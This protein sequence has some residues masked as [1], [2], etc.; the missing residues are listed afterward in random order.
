MPS[1]YTVNLGIEKPA[2]GEQSGTWGDTTNLNFDI[3]DQAI[4]GAVSITLASAGT[5]GSPNTL[6]ISDGAVSDG[7]NKW[8]EFVDGGDLGATAYVQLT[9]N[10]AEKIV[11]VRNSLSGSRS[12]ILFQGTYDAGRDLEVPAGVDMLVKFDGGGATATTTNVFQRL[13]VENLNIAGTTTVNGVID[14]DTM[15]TASA[16]TLATSESIKAYVDT[17]AA[18]Q[19][20]LSEV[21]ANGN[22]TGGTDIAVSS[23]DDITFA[24]NSKAIFGASSDL[25]IYHSGSDSW[26]EDNGA[27]NLYIDT[28][29]AGI[30]LSYN[31]SAENMATFTANGAVTLYYDNAAKFATTST[32]VDITGAF[33]ATTTGTVPTIYGGSGASQTF[34][35]QSTSGNSNHSKVLIGNTVGADNGG[36]SFY[37][38]GT[39]VATERMR[40]SGT[41]GDITFYDTSGN[42]SF[43]YDE[44][45]GSTFNEQ[46]ENKDFRVES[47]SN[48]NMLFVDA[49]VDRVYVGTA[50]GTSGNLVVASN[51]GA[52][53][54]QIN[55]RVGD[56]YG[57]LNFYNNA[58]DTAWGA[59]AGYSGTGL[60]FYQGT[61]EIFRINNS[62]AIF[63][64]AGNNRDF[65]VESDGNAYAFFVDADQD[66]VHIGGSGGNY[67]A[68]I[69]GNTVNSP[70]G[71]LYVNAALNNS[72]RGVFIDA[73][74]RTE[75]DNSTRLLQVRDRYAYNALT[76]NVGGTVEINDDGG[77]WGDFRVESDA[78]ANM[79]WVDAGQNRVKIATASD[80]GAGVLNID[81]AVYFANSSNK[82][83]QGLT[84]TGWGYSPGTYG[85]IQ[86]GGPN[87]GGTV[88]IGY[89]PSGN[90]NGSFTGN[91]IE[92]LF[93]GDIEFYQ[94]NP[95][96]TGWVRQLRMENG[97]G[98]TINEAGADLDFRVES[99]TETHMLFVDA[100][101]NRI[102]VMYSSPTANGIHV[103]P[104]GEAQIFIGSAN[105]GGAT[106]LLDGDANGDGSG[107]DYAYIKH[108]T[109]GNLTIENLAPSGTE[110]AVN[111][112]GGN[113]N[114]RVEGDTQ[115]H[116]IFADAGNNSVSI[117]TSQS[118]NALALN[119][120]G[121]AGY[122]DIAGY[123][124]VV[125][126]ATSVGVGANQVYVAAGGF[127]AAG[128]KIGDEIYISG[129]SNAINTVT[130]VT[131]TVL[132]CTNNWTQSFAGVS[133][134]G[135]SAVD[136]SA[137]YNTRLGVRVQAD[138][139]VIIN[140]NGNSA[141][142]FR[143]E[144][145]TL[146]EAIFVD[147]STNV[148]NIGGNS[149][150]ERVT[151]HS[152][153]LRV[154]GGDPSATST[155]NGLVLTGGQGS[156]VSGRI[157][158]GDGTGW[159]M[160]WS[161]KYLGTVSNLHTFYDSGA[162]VF[163]EIGNDAN[164]RI[165]SDTNANMFI[166][167]A[168]ES[169]IGIGV[170]PADNTNGGLHVG[171]S[172]GFSVGDGN[173]ACYHVFTAHQ[174]NIVSNTTSNVM[175][176]E[177]PAFARYVKVTMSGYLCQ[178]EGYFKG[179]QSWDGQTGGAVNDYVNITFTTTLGSN[180]GATKAQ[181][182][183]T[184]TSTSGTSGYPVYRMD[185]ITGS[186]SGQLYDTSVTVEFFNPPYYAVVV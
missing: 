108:D 177:G 18:A 138:G 63:N 96:D 92:M 158:V 133:C 101:T 61:T 142:D 178:Q 139:S 66:T 27:G 157:F 176:F 173:T 15:A 106:L 135:Y 33:T 104:S 94:P 76:I 147:A 43:V 99:D 57:F 167:D 169:K 154:A 38:A 59:I 14:D 10:D 23:G 55:A 2:T 120:K 148:I 152:G 119:V 124:W 155:N 137:G 109:S 114:F 85:V 125:N 40:I 1:T 42:A 144:T 13:R 93:A 9:P 186:L 26:I 163:N 164:F 126:N 181:I 156:P 7:R 47:D 149:G 73:A 58:A 140:D 25:Q 136:I 71:A 128:A 53:G 39:S 82:V 46:G 44:S 22:T 174:G 24:D 16:T 166:L 4:N 170:P 84:P 87:Q 50:T 179:Y 78:D 21:L 153:A 105:S 79:L 81:G 34:T 32:G 67:V 134:S 111:D 180:S 60:L 103:R 175:T 36:I 168:G 117:N 165:E 161:K 5:S 11:L 30:N 45:A 51:A 150:A 107:G 185:I 29:G 98:I 131:D 68:N 62:G 69:Y 74:T 182:R 132:T 80:Y 145:D 48:A 97:T 129:T 65:R 122:Q 64:E 28:N 6:A 49:G 72:G 70:T 89:D 91:G 115:T 52:N 12:V 19:N 100:S 83:I 183:L 130:A 159:Q 123:R 151:I 160:H 20:E 121:Y 141:Q 88:S 37:S 3:L 90:A 113:M 56:D 143:V 127:V 118:S 110:I 102:G 31:N 54:I 112:N 41:T 146:S 184:V 162:V 77:D 8:I 86:L 95:T 17:T 35:L 172:K 171:S 116:L 75:L